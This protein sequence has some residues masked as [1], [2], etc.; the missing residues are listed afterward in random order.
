MNVST[1][2]PLHLS[3]ERLAD[4]CRQ[5]RQR[6]PD[7]AQAL[8]LLTT[9]RAF[10]GMCVEDRNHPS[11]LAAQRDLDALTEELR[12]ALLAQHAAQL[13]DALRQHDT[14]II[15]RSFMALSRSGFAA[16]AASA[17]TRLEPHA[18][19]DGLTWLNA[20]TQDARQRAVAAGRYPDA[21]DFR[22]AGIA[23]ET[24]LA[25]EELRDVAEKVDCS[26]D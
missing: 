1:P 3:P 2:I 7:H 11:W 14:A 8:Q 20:W 18:R 15:T 17:W 12:T 13:G 5:L 26:A 24:C 22:A 9:L 19:S 21:P 4:F 10:L 6:T 23:L 16:A 25:M